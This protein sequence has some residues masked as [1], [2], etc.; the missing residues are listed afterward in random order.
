MTPGGSFLFAEEEEEGDISSARLLTG[1]SVLPLH[2]HRNPGGRG[3]GL[4]AL[5]CGTNLLDDECTLYDNNKKK[6]WG[7]FCSQESTEQERKLLKLPPYRN[8]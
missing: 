7:F 4:C 2:N 8:L 6:K 5:K 1:Q 3:E